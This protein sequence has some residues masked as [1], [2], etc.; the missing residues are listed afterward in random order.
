L[1]A[2]SILRIAASL[3]ASLTLTMLA[4][5][6]ASA[7]GYPNKPIR[8]IVTYPPGGSTDIATRIV[9]AELQK[10]INQTVIVENR[11][12]GGG[13]IGMD[14]TAKAAP[15]G[16][17]LGVGVS[18]TLTIGPAL[19]NDMPYKPL[20]DLAPVTLIVNN[21]L[22]L[23]SSL[24]FP[25][26][27]VPEFLAYAKTQ[28]EGLTFGSGGQA[29]AMHL[30]G[31]MLGATTG[32]N[33]QH[34]PYR[35]TSPAVQDLI[36]GHVPLAIIDSA[37]VREFIK[38]GKV[39]GIATTGAKRSP[40]APEL[41][42]LSESGVPGFVVT[43][44]FGIL[45]PGG[46]PPDVVRLLNSHIV[47]ILKRHDVHEKFLAVGLEPATNTPEEFRELIRS[48]TERYRAVIVRNKITME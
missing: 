25:A 22:V 3:A 23:A 2:S 39:R 1:K 16:Y 42:T 29:T 11:P 7:Q 6:T 19:R 48:E 30:A 4:V 37:T 17:T 15:D 44:W 26:K 46:T 8:I 47:A 41:P 13:I 34:V 33:L 5:P 20:T 28:P 35:G 45:A 12:G 36:A 32:I 24:A 31:A 40:T 10:R 27:T 9:A 43:S 38:Q 21:P 14:A 18:G